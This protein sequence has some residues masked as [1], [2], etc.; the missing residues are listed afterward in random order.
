MGVLTGLVMIPARCC[1]G[2]FEHIHT[3]TPFDSWFVAC[4]CQ[5]KHMP[6]TRRLSTRRHVRAYITRA[7]QNCNAEVTILMHA[8][9]FMA[10]EL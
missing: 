5:G 7:V 9:T 4:S 8:I 6:I 10:D 1:C 2:M 3:G